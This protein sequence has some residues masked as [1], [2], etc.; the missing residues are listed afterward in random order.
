[1]LTLIVYMI[2]PLDVGPGSYLLDKTDLKN[3]E[4]FKP[5]KFAKRDNNWGS[6][7]RFD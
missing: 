4:R 7:K 6:V 1:M 3:L 5:A 2:A